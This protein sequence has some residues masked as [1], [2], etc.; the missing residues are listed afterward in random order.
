MFY[1]MVSAI[2][3]NMGT[4]DI[5]ADER[6]GHPTTGCALKKQIASQNFGRLYPLL[7]GYGDHDEILQ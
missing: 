6:G 7:H 3:G 1:S 5:V 4:S 2:Y